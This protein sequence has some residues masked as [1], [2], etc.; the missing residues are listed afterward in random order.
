MPSEGDLWQD[1]QKGIA[2]RKCFSETWTKISKL[3][4]EAWLWRAVSPKNRVKNNW[5]YQDGGKWK[6]SSAAFA[7]S[8]GASCDL[9]IFSSEEKSRRGWNSHEP[10]PRGTFL[11]KF[12][13]LAVKKIDASFDVVH[14]PINTDPIVNYSHSVVALESTGLPTKID[15]KKFD[16]AEF[17]SLVEILPEQD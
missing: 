12:Q 2:A 10:R 1:D 9:A 13:V 6:F 17:K 11:L 7:Q 5:I 4:R 15:V 14:D 8:T 16:M 3:P